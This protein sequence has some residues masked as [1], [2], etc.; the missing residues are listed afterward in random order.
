MIYHDIVSWA[1]CWFQLLQSGPWSCLDKNLQLDSGLTQASDSSEWEIQHINHS[2]SSI[3]MY[4]N[5]I[6][7][8]GWA[9]NSKKSPYRVGQKKK[10]FCRDKKEGYIKKTNPSLSMSVELRWKVVK[11]RPSFAFFGLPWQSSRV[12]ITKPKPN[13]W[14]I[15]PRKTRSK[16]PIAKIYRGMKHLPS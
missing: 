10:T 15:I 14:L 16:F 3:E 13:K 6:D 2:D 12:V 8:I 4:I 11:W 9:A 1:L 7:I 5:I